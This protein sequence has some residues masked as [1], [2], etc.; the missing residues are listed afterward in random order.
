MGKRIVI[1]GGVAAG[2]KTRGCA[3]PIGRSLFLANR[4]CPFEVAQPSATRVSHDSIKRS[5]FPV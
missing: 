3:S 2:M 4:F 5:P 1:I